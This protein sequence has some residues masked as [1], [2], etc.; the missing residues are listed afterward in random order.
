MPCSTFSRAVLPH[1]RVCFALCA[2]AAT[3]LGTVR[4]VS[5]ASLG[6]VQSAQTA[7]TGSIRSVAASPTDPVTGARHHA[8]IS[9]SALQAQES[10]AVMPFEVA[11]SM[12]HFDELESRLAHSE[13]ISRAELEARYLPLPTDYARVRDWLKSE[14]FAVTGDKTNHLA[15]FARG[16]VADVGRVLHATFARV[17][18]ADGEFTSAITPP[19]VPTR[20]AGVI[21]GIHG[22][23]PFQRLHLRPHALQ[24]LVGT[25]SSTPYYPAQIAQAYGAT[26]LGLTG[27]GQTIAVYALAVPSTS[28]L[29]TFWSNAGVAATAANIQTINVAGGPASN[30]SAGSVEEATLDVEWASALAPGAAIRVYAASEID[31]VADDELIQQILA[32]L[33]SNPSLHQL[34]ISF[35]LDENGAD[36]DYIAIEA[37]YMAT[38]VSS[39]VTV[40]AAS[41]DNGAL[42]NEKLS[43]QTGFPASMPDVTAVGG[44]SLTLDSSANILTETAWGNLA[45]SG[46]TGGSGGG[47]SVIFNRPS[48]QNVA[49]APA[50]TMRL[51]PDVAAAGDPATPAY[52]VYKSRGTSVGGTSW[53]SPIWAAWCALINQARANAGKQ[54]LGALNPRLYPLAGTAAFH[55]ITSGGNSIY[56]AD[57]GYDLV[58]GLGT[59]NVA[60][61]LQ[62]MMSDSFAPVIEVG[63]GNR[64]TTTGQG[65]TFYVIATSTPAPAFQW[66]RLAAGSS[67][68]TVLNDSGSYAG[69]A[70]Y[71]LSVSNASSAMNGDQFR[72]V[73]TNSLGSTT[74]PPA[75]LTVSPTGVSTLAGWPGWSGYA[76]GRG[77]AGR[78]N[79]TG[80][81]RTDAAGN[82]YV[83][84]A[85]NNTVR[86]V[87]P[88]GTVTT[89]AGS[90]GVAG[91]ADGVG[92]AA[93][94]DGPAGV[95]IDT[96]GNV[97]VADSQ[98]YTI[99]KITP[100]GVVTTLAGSAGV[101]GHADGQGSAASFYDPEDLAID[102]SGNLY[103]ADGQGNELRKVSPTG[104][105]TTLAGAPNSG[106]ADG[107]GSTARFNLLAGVAVDGDGNVYVG[108]MLN[109][110]V[111]R[112]T[113]T[114][115]VTTL[116][117]LGGSSNYGFVDGQGM[118]ARL[119]GPAGMSIDAAGNLYVADIYNNAVRKITPS[120]KVTTL[121]GSSTN[122]ENIDGP[123][124]VARFNQP[125][126]VAIDP[127]GV[128]YVADSY[129]CTVRRIALAPTIVVSPAAQAVV[130]GG[131]LTLSVS[132]AGTGPFTY[133]WAKDGTAIPGATTATYTVKSATVGT[134]GDY[135]V[136]VS[137]DT[138]IVSSA[139]ALVTVN[140]SS[141]GTPSRLANLSVRTGAGTG[142]QTLT[143]GFVLS[144]TPNKTMLIRAVGPGLAGFN[145]DGTLP[146]P[147]LSVIGPAPSTAVAASD[148]NWNTADKATMD[149]VGAFPLTA[150]SKDAAV[151]VA[152]PS[153]NYS[154]QVTDA[155]GAT[156]IAL[157]EIYD[158]APGSGARLINVSARAQVGTGDGVLTVGFVISGGSSETV[159][160]RGIGPGLL[161][162][163]VNDALGDPRLDVYDSNDNVLQS[164]DNWG[165]AA[166]LT[167]AFHQTGAFLLSD[168][169]SKDAALVITLPP[170][171]YTA[172]V[173]SVDQSPGVALVEVY[174]IP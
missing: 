43:I 127:N 25:G 27:A 60:A 26:G 161:P 6:A 62:A 69:T 168:P 50:G 96:A 23:Q 171:A 110:T 115:V 113:P 94:F 149:T 120:G 16:S 138:G 21:R 64:F 128:I 170:G 140:S 126:D 15:V 74:S 65:A 5:A 95:A 72:C 49:G 151:V 29:T 141:N 156:G 165:G 53:S 40:F 104:T 154:A 167:T 98:N 67:T 78:F 71:A 100:S 124:S 146:D 14:G 139:G 125:T 137:S 87:T 103:I 106:T 117:G 81:V 131:T 166:A 93:L 61:L 58:T 20:L 150:G 8:Y 3:L 75:T 83:A 148:D 162:Y 133:Q 82:V 38:L 54:P 147:V 160:I 114:G 132:V 108:D 121:A 123:L 136:I 39:G 116:A 12:R 36:R 144:G 52:I 102:G 30:T 86:K 1:R 109:N 22:L 91:S 129:N 122:P 88:N 34:T 79:Y 2:T 105:V 48:W 55:D 134:A 35:G 158:T 28:D 45:N 118:S 24:P 41:G 107:T 47:V 159:L 18:T 119:D 31:P 153:A 80:S 174:E 32:D 84:D 46:T 97:Y 99:R 130:L 37:Q 163:G 85:S 112:V 13:I 135:S 172:Q 92:S 51:V 90:P 169:A 33:P 142:A 164:N 70:T 155:T 7:L 10:A 89:L 19:S 143:V 59:P 101:Q 17:T 152:L 63:S 145:V 157:A 57:V 66:Q 77:S 56:R 76:D 44:T 42:D 11:L 173:G 111:R 68:W 9:R 4:T 73:I